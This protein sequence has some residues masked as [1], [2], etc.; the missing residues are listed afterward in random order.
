MKRL[1]QRRVLFVLLGMLVLGGVVSL[2]RSEPSERVPLRVVREA[3][4]A[5]EVR[6]DET[7]G[8]RDRRLQEALESHFEDPVTVRH[9]DL[10][11]TGAGRRALLLWGRLLQSY[12]SARLSGEQE[13]VSLSANGG[14]ATVRMRVVL[15]AEKAGAT[16]SDER[17]V[18]VRLR[19]GDGGWKIQRV[20]VEPSAND[21][22]EARP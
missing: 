18:D 11:Q 3:L 22:P 16:L 10:P 20:D 15:Q 17:A 19:K 2:W 1:R 6:A 12:G 7:P 9:V 8:K 14:S 5:T 13:Q 21:I 4:A